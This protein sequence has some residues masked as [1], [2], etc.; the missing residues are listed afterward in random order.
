MI[1]AKIID[2]DSELLDLELPRCESELVQLTYDTS[3]AGKELKVHA[4]LRTSAVRQRH[5]MLAQLMLAQHGAPHH[6]M[7]FSLGE[8]LRANFC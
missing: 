8:H 4:L 3:P 7:N 6:D 2:Q 5:P 1:R